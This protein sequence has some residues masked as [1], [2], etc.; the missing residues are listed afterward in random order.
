MID[1]SDGLASDLLHICRQSKK[2]ATIYEDKIAIDH[3]VLSVSEEL[4]IPALTMALN[5]G[6]DYELLFSVPLDQYD[7]VKAM[8]GVTIIGHIVEE[9]AGVNLITSGGAMLPVQAQGWNHF[10]KEQ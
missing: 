4:G 3:E 6:E 9:A 7:K 8:K 5:G 10:R 2:G 1:V